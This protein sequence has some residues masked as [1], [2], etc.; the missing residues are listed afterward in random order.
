MPAAPQLFGDRLTHRGL[1]SNFSSLWLTVFE[2]VSGVITPTTTGPTWFS[3]L[4]AALHSAYNPDKVFLFSWFLDLYFSN[5]DEK[6]GVHKCI[7]PMNFTR[8]RF[9]D[10]L[11]RIYPYMKSKS[12]NFVFWKKLCTLSFLEDARKCKNQRILFL[13]F[14][15]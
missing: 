7:D 5:W 13:F 15:C 10:L 8:H 1:K 4:P 12:W 9:Q 11:L 3:D 14:S 6:T 2:S